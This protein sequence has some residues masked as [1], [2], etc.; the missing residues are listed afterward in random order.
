MHRGAGTK[1]VL[2]LASGGGVGYLPYCPG[3]LGTAIALPVA[4]AI[5][6]IA[7]HEAWLGAISLAALT[8]IAVWLADHA[9]RI[10]RL[11]EKG[12]G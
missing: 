4:L 3:T 6:R 9:A 2:F 10:G 7:S 1:I 5:N 8:A 11:L 12:L